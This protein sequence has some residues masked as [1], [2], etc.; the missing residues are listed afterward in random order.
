[1][2]GAPQ[3]MT[4]DFMTFREQQLCRDI[5]TE[6]VEHEICLLTSALSHI[7]HVDNMAED[8]SVLIMYREVDQYCAGASRLCIRSR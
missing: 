7:G 4:D 1:M 6:M 3:Y 2:H 5:R 8:R